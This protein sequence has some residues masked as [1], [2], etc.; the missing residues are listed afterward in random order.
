MMKNIYPTDKIVRVILAFFLLYFSGLELNG[1]FLAAAALLLSAVSNFCPLYKALGVNDKY[2]QTNKFLNSL[3]KNNPEPVFIFSNQGKLIFQNQASLDILPTIKDFYTL[4][5]A[6]PREIINAQ[7]KLSTKYKYNE[8]IY[9]LEA[10]G[11]AQEDY[12]L[13]YGFNITG[14]EKSREA[15]K[16]QRVTDSLTQLGNTEKLLEDV[17]KIQDHTLSLIIFDV[18]KFSQINGFFGHEKGDDFLVQFALQILEF[19]ET[20][21]I[22]VSAYRLRGN[23]FALLLD[24]ADSKNSERDLELTQ[25]K[26][27]LLEKFNNFKL[28]INNLSATTDIRMGIA[29]EK[30]LLHVD[31]NALLG[32]TE[33]ALSEAKIQNKPF[34][35][36]CDISDIN[37]RY[38]KNL[39]WADKLY[40]IF[41]DKSDAQ[42]KAYYQ[43]IYNLHTKKIEKFEALVR[44]Q[45]QDKL[46]SP[47]VFLDVAKQI[48]YLPKITQEVLHQATNTFKNTPYEFSINITT[49]DLAKEHFLAN[50][51]AKLA[52][53]GIQN[54]SVVLEILEDEDIYEFSETINEFKKLGFKIAIDDFGVGYSN[55]KKLQLLR[56]DYIK[57]DA[58]LVKNIATNPKDLEII[59]SIC[60]YAKAID[61]KTIAEFVANKEIFELVKTSGVD[62][63]QGYYISE[64]KPSIEVVFD[65]Q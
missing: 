55:F 41:N 38:A 58:S 36:F 28:Q 65:A 21:K 52:Q 30:C 17:E 35:Y 45:D 49:Q 9:M 18:I 6:N 11:L 61:V 13:T 3:P 12:I 40:G 34:I 63:V 33:T 26:Q 4:F 39:Q 53:A 44:I 29:S 59:R 22:L 31:A 2:A 32:N 23:T 48:N 19:K 56:A 46:I 64:P 16:I 24:F 15:L 10:V 5:Q 57:I 27:K 54:S 47:F 42:I 43:P 20:L 37:E 25:I 8:K 62:Y 51:A 50:I 1:Y 14:I 60:S 7:S